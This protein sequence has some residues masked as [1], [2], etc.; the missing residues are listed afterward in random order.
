MHEQL[1]RAVNRDKGS[2]REGDGLRITCHTD[3]TDMPVEGGTEM[4]TVRLD[5][6]LERRQNELAEAT[7]CS[8]SHYVRLAIEGFLDD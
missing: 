3:F 8:K 1:S 4:L 7:G 5:P 6:D 2:R